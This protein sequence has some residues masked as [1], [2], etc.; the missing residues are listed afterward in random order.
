MIMPSHQG[1]VS[2][3]DCLI[4]IM[5]ISIAEKMAFMLQRGPDY[6]QSISIYM[7]RGVLSVGRHYQNQYV[8]RKTYV[9]IKS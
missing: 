4:F 1:R 6:L 7:H 8:W 3:N 9:Y 5:V 2:N